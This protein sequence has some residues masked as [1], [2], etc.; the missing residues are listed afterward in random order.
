MIEQYFE[1][2]P[3]VRSYMDDTV[4]FAREHGF[5]ETIL[6]RRRYLKDI[7]SRS[8]AARK[9]AERNAINSPVQ[10]TAADMIKLAMTN[11]HQMQIERGWQTKMLLQVHDELVFDLFLEEQEEVMSAV[12]E[13]MKNCLGFC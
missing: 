10:G 1:E 2:Y 7:N 12:E 9:A 6:G 5:V 4:E 13:A 11:I 3:G 8:V